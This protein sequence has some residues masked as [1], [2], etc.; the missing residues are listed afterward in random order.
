MKQMLNDIPTLFHISI[1]TF[2]CEY[3]LQSIQL[4][5]NFELLNY[6]F[7]PIMWPWNQMIRD[8]QNTKIT[9]FLEKWI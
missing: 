7:Q 8:R 6:S 9:M 5:F 3:I 2:I 1:S 4:Y